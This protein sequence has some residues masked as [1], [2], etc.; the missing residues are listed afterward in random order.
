[1][2][3]WDSILSQVELSYNDTI[4]RNIRKA[5][6]QIVYGIHPRGVLELR[7]LPKEDPFSADGEAFASAIKEVHDQ[8]KSHLQ[9]F[10]VKYKAHADK[11]KRDVQFSVGDLVWVHLKKERLPNGK[12]TKIMQRKIGPCQILKKYGQN[13]YEIQIPLDLGLSPIFNVCNLTL[14]KGSDNEGE[15]PM[16]VAADNDIP[17]HESLKMR[18]VLDTRVTKKTRKKE[19]IDY[20]VAW[21]DKPNSEAV[22]MTSEQISNHGA[23]LQ[24]P[25]SSRLEISSPR[26]NGAGAP[27]QHSN[28]DPKDEE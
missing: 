20:L 5:P 10:A 27:H 2:E 6:F 11:K 22:W 1:M 12:Y 19:Y 26:E 21:Q 3:R 16:Q 13:S 17:K 24:T 28:H 14:F 9:Q 25:I 18:K 7:E 23:D 15:E 4:N 8:V